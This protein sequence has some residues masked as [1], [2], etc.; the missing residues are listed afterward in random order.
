MYVIEVDIISDLITIILGYYVTPTATIKK[1]S[2]KYTQDELKKE[3]KHHYKE[4]PNIKG[5]NGRKHG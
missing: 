3:S 2:I 1:I 4:S 5:S